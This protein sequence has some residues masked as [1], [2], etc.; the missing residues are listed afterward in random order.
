MYKYIFA[1]QEYSRILK[2]TE[3]DGWGNLLLV[4][5]LKLTYGFKRIIVTS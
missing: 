1:S 3:N 4:F 2:M 5:A